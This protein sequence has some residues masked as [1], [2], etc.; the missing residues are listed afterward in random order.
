MCVSVRTDPPPAGEQAGPTCTRENQKYNL[1]CVYV[2]SYFFII[3]SLVGTILLPVLSSRLQTHS[4]NTG[5]R[6]PTQMPR[7]DR[8]SAGCCVAPEPAPFLAF[9]LIVVMPRR[10][11]RFCILRR[12]VQVNA[13]DIVALRI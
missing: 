2:K 11:R 8:S 12:E 13:D 1:W 4:W 6:A 5:A 7:A 9:C 3:Y 10:G